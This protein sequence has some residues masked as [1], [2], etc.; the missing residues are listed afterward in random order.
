MTVNYKAYY[1][2]K[3]LFET[4]IEAHDVLQTAVQFLEGSQRGARINK[5]LE[6]HL[7]KLLTCFVNVW[8]IYATISRDFQH[9][10]MFIPSLFKAAIGYYGVD[11]HLEEIRKLREKRVFVDTAQA[12]I[13]AAVNGNLLQQERKDKAQT[14]NQ[15]TIKEKLPFDDRNPAWNFWITMHN[16]FRTETHT[17]I[18]QWLFEDN[19]IH[20]AFTAILWQLLESDTA[21]Q[22][23]AHGQCK[24]Y[25]GHYSSTPD[26]W[27]NLIMNYAKPGVSKHRRTFFILIDGIDQVDYETN[28]LEIANTLSYIIDTLARL[29]G[30]TFQVRLLLTGSDKSFERVQSDSVAFLH[31]QTRVPHEVVQRNIRASIKEIS[32]S[33]G[34]DLQRDRLLKNFEDKLCEH[35]SRQPS[36]VKTILDSIHGLKRK[37]DLKELLDSNWDDPTASG[38]AWNSSELFFS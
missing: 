19:T 4:L 36:T 18:G 25:P 21:Y 8:T 1:D 16:K 10:R 23:F 3:N 31:L 33:R 32:E 26:R 11:K 30:G 29:Q 28:E 14:Q 12:R 6:D 37:K 7:I 38:Q 2:P 22:S 13:E 15:K 27:E 34:R 20:D 17:G 5:P 35:Y 9:R 24:S